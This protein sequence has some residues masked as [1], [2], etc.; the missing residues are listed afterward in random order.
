MGVNNVPISQSLNPLITS[1]MPTK[2]KT[3]NPKSKIISISQPARGVTAVGF[4]QQA[5]GQ[6]RFYWN[7]HD[8]I[9]FAGVGVAAE[10]FAW[11][12]GRFESIQT[13][14]RA[15]FAGA[16]V[17]A[18]GEPL[19]VPR[20][21]GGFAFRDDFVPD[22]TWASFHPAHFVLPHYQL[23]ER[24]GE[25]W[26]TLNA[27]IPAT[28]DPAPLIPELRAALAAKIA[29]LRATAPAR[30]PAP[31]AS[32]QHS[33]LTFEQWAEL[34]TRATAA[35]QA[36]AFQKVVLARVCEVRM[37]QSLDVDAALAYL[38]QTYPE[39]YRFLFEPRPH[40]AFYGAT[41]EL[42]ARVR[43]TAVETMGLAG[44]APRGRDPQT[45]AALGAA[46]L[47]SAKDRHE[48]QLVVDS[49]GRRLTPL[50]ST[51]TVP[52]TPQLYTLSNI[53]HLH[54]PITGTLHHATGVLPVVAEL[55]PTPALG[56]TPRETAVRF[57]QE[58]ESVTRGWYAAPIGWL[59]HHLDGVFGVAIR[60]AVAQDNRAWAYAGAG[61]V[62]QSDPTAEWQET[63]VKLRPMLNALGIAN[64]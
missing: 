49:I 32:T 50:T 42:L 11:G 19:A 13:Q 22:N 61:I 9:T 23:L 3:Q 26:L 21:F 17:V 18:D 57:I 7:D 46:L 8:P 37:G 53:H 56:G 24:E 48:H 41:P 64:S 5:L 31:T 14:A 27:Q 12:S 45:D 47:I 10:L 38:N 2:S 54:T 36:G 6:P 51:L 59:D 34:V 63:G 15:L 44:S 35:I 33:T 30:P 43:G 40:H 20:L 4:L 58:T 25:A 1:P 29:E 39:C 60:S 55:H 16:V 52:A 28:E 62:A